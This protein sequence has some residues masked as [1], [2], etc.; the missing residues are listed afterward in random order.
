[1]FFFHISSSLVNPQPNTSGHAKGLTRRQPF[2]GFVYQFYR[3]RPKIAMPGALYEGLACFFTQYAD[4]QNA[5][6]GGI[7]STHPACRMRF[8]YKG[9]IPYPE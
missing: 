3:V 9:F 2:N 7:S 6:H 1:M 8:S 5:A 4:G